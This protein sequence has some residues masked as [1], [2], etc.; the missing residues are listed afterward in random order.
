[1]TPP[2]PTAV[3]PLLL[4]AWATRCL[5]DRSGPDQAT[6]AGP[7]Q[8]GA[9]LAVLDAAVTAAAPH[10]GAWATRLALTAA[11]AAVARSGRPEDEAAVAFS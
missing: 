11:T 10:A 3:P 2:S 9:A 7:A 8:I 4:P 1:M 6:P 5:S